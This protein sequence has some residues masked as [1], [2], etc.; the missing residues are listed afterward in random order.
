M[1]VWNIVKFSFLLLLSSVIDKVQSYSTPLPPTKR[2][3]NWE[4]NFEKLKKYK[5]IHGN[6][7]VPPSFPQDKALGRW[8]RRQRYELKNVTEDNGGNEISLYRRQKLKD[9]GFT[10][11]Q[12]QDS[13]MKYYQE[14]IEFKR[15]YGH[16][17]V[18]PYYH[19]SKRWKSLSLWVRNQRSQYIKYQKGISKGCFLTKDRIKLLQKIGFQWNVQ[20]DKWLRQYNK[21]L[22][23]QKKFGTLHV[24][25]QYEADPSLSRWV[26]HQ[27]YVMRQTSKEDE[28]H[29][30]EMKHSKLSPERIKLLNDIGFLWKIPSG[31][32][33]KSQAVMVADKKRRNKKESP[34]KQHIKQQPPP[35]QTKKIIPFPWDEI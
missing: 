23:F 29:R 14:L 10:F 28:N 8:V 25:T 26:S 20:E 1:I 18:S 5:E 12:I 32:K 24:P 33:G 15:T 4:S 9:L 19:S 35:G 2:N 34:S 22:E 7:N 11:D 13:W 17:M 3:L 27:R 21:L 31:R 30:T 16:T 6:C